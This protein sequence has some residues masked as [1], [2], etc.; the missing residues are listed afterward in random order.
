MNTRRLLASALKNGDQTVLA[1]LGI[2]VAY[3][4]ASA[5]DYLSRTRTTG[6]L[7]N[8]GIECFEV[9]SDDKGH[10]V[11]S[12]TPEFA[13]SMPC[14]EEMNDTLIC[15]SLISKIFE[16][17]NYVAYREKIDRYLEDLAINFSEPG[18]E[19]NL[20]Y[21]LFSPTSL[22][23]NTIPPST[24]SSNDRYPYRRELIWMHLNSDLS[25]S[26]IAESY[27][28]FLHT[29][30]PPQVGAESPATVSL[31]CRLGKRKSEVPHTCHGYG[32]EAVTLTPD[33][34]HNRIVVFNFPSVNERCL[35]C[36]KIA[37][38]HVLSVGG[39][40]RGGSLYVTHLNNLAQRN[41]FLMYFQDSHHGSQHDGYWTSIV[42]LNNVE[43]GR[44]TGRTGREAREGAAHQALQI[45]GFHN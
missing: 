45:L 40:F 2:Q 21:N 19:L 20:S 37:K 7:S 1:A 28:D 4:I 18:P 6:C 36:G 43:H 25:L 17:V 13:S 35:L 39:R 11:L 33:A 31:P 12:L 29:R 41:G 42:Y 22:E 14:N 30:S 26:D 5:L 9:F 16:E 38:L 32:R 27:G 24:S 10:T 34:F 23:T 3:G 15:N 44:A 8:F